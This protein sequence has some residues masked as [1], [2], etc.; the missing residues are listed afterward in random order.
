MIRVLSRN[1]MFKIDR[2]GF[3]KNVIEVESRVN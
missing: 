1:K 3:V 2:F